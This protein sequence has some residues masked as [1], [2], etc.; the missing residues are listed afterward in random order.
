MQNYR[1]KHCEAVVVRRLVREMGFSLFINYDG[2][3]EYEVGIY[4]HVSVTLITKG[5]PDYLLAELAELDSP[6]SI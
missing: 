2:R 6:P 1:F 5:V 3:E 4:E